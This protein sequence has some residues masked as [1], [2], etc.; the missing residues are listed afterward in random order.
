MYTRVPV[1]AQ[2]MAHVEV[3]GA[4]PSLECWRDKAKSCPPETHYVQ[5]QVHG[6]TDE[7]AEYDLLQGKV[8]RWLGEE[9]E[10]SAWVGVGE[11][12]SW[13]S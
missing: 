12:P 2:Q 6:Q 5:R 3:Y 10:G 1:N 9:R 13:R 11:T 4:G 7:V 8:K